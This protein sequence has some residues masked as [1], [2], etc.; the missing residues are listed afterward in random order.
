MTKY[1][2][3]KSS[4]QNDNFILPGLKTFFSIPEESTEKSQFT[5]LAILDESADSKE[6]VLKVVN[7]LH[8]KFQPLLS[9][10]APTRE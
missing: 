3:S 7:I 8:E 5:S 6:T 2:F 1:G 9:L 10:P 4:F